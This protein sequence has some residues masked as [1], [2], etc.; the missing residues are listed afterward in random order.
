MRAPWKSNLF[1]RFFLFYLVGAVVISI[2]LHF[3][4]ET[5]IRN[6]YLT[7]VS[8]ELLEKSK[9]LAR[10]LPSRVEGETLDRICRD[11]ARNSGSR[12]TVIALDGRVLGDSDQPS[13]SMENHGIRPEVVE[14][15]SDGVGSSVRYSETVRYEMLYQ[16]FLQRD[17]DISRI[18]RVSVPLD[19]IERTVASIRR[20]ILIGL[21]LVS[22]LGLLMAFFFSRHLRL[23]VRRMADFSQQVS[24]GCFPKGPIQ[25]TREDELGILEKNLSHMSDDL[26]ERMK[27]IVEE[28]EKVESIL[29]CMTEGVLVVDT[30]GRLI[31][32]NQNA[33]RMFSLPAEAEFGGA[34]FLEVS[35]HPEMK[36][37][38][39][40]VLGCDCA[41]EC[42]AKEVALEGNKWF[43][44]SAVSLQG[45]DERRLGY[46]LVFHD[47]TELK[48]LETMRADFVANVS[49]EIRTPLAAI[50]GYAETLLRNPPKEPETARHF[51]KVIDRHSERLGRLID[52]LLAIADFEAGKIELAKEHIQ[53]GYLVERVLEIFQDQARNKN[54]TLSST[55]DGDL[56]SIVG[57]S[58]RL[59]QLLINL[60]DNALKYTPSG[61]RI[62][63]IARLVS[64][65]NHRPAMVEISVADTGCG[66]SEKDLPRLTERFYRVDKARSRELGGTGLGLAIVKHI[67]Q[68]HEG[69]LKIESQLRKGTTI[70]VSLPV[71]DEARKR[72]G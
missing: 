13:S 63:I 66:I 19:T 47:V 53:P 59:Q 36:T 1:V 16:A 35:R 17:Q 26:Q 31:L 43:R 27:A 45:G 71:K 70:R 29:R 18:I 4:S 52:D 8:N 32:L 34:S 67:V 68:A 15:L 39:R 28:K 58:D 7:S 11:L 46:I 49:H 69:L 25:V 38:M 60:I 54:I 48:R 65:N 6:F 44:V 3:Y 33:R 55:V 50:K 10:L 9:L 21:L 12:I 72:L 40:E 62:E 20:V 42:F 14:A 23:R 22:A 5:R 2:L 24:R 30:Q 41:K 61:G 37:L 64:S 51:L 57:D 56:P